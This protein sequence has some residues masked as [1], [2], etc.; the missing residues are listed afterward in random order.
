MPKKTRKEKIR[1][2]KHRTNAPVIQH[3]QHTEDPHVV[4]QPQSTYTFSS[5]AEKKNLQRAKEYAVEL[6]SITRDIYKT[7]LL[8]A[9][10]FGVEWYMYWLFQQKH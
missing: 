9:V 6:G 2:Q 4:S 5:S 3:T 7:L 8:A 1:A 10:A